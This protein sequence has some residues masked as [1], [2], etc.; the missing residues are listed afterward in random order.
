MLRTYKRVHGILILLKPNEQRLDL[1]FKF[2]VQELLT[3]L[4]RDAARNIAFGFTNTR[5][6]NYLPG[7]T[8]DPL[9]QLL[10]R[11]DD[12]NITLRKDSVYCFDS[13]SFRHLAAMKTVEKSMGQLAEN[14]ASWEYSVSEAK[15]LLDH[16]AK[17]PPHDVISTVNLY[18]TRFRIVG[19]TRP[20]ATIADAIR[21]TILVNQDDLKELSDISERGKGLAKLLKVKVKTVSAKFVDKPRTMCSHQDCI[22][23][24]ATC[25]SGVD[26]KGILKTV[27]KSACHSPCYLDNFQLDRV[28]DDHLRGCWAMHGEVQDHCRVCGHPWMD[29]LHVDYL[30]EEGMKEVEDPDIKALMKSN[31]STRHKKEAGIAAKKHLIEELEAELN[32][33][34]SAAA[35]FGI[36]LKRNAIMPYNDATLDYLDRCIEEE[37]GK[38]QAGSSG[39]KLENLKQY[40]KEYEQEINHLEEYMTKGTEELLL[41]QAGVDLMMK[42]VYSLK[43][44]GS[45]LSDMCNVIQNLPSGADRERAHM[46]RAKDH[47]EHPKKHRRSNKA[48]MQDRPGPTPGQV[49]FPAS[50]YDTTGQ[51]PGIV[52][53]FTQWLTPW[54]F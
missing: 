38:V 9:K 43:H 36:F 22:E 11:F 50:K 8:F 1:M 34:R 54:K 27:Y 10:Q 18:E 29:H 23:H 28:G 53:R 5:G 14:R 45:M 6:T 17:L 26:G 21:S 41:D 2:C 39:D 4:H 40:R 32:T 3:H 16:F 51:Q 48:S 44:Y 49:P 12:I 33:I 19:M 35:Q 31:A 25:V 24:S 46:L 37:A 13:E 20:M 42:D 15:R 7:D 47:W 52:K 30:L